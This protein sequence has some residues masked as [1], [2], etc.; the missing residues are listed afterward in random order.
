VIALSLVPNF[1]P[2][3]LISRENIGIHLTVNIILGIVAIVSNTH[4]ENIEKEREIENRRNNAAALYSLSR[5]LEVR[6][7]ETAGHSVRAVDLTIEL[8]K[9]CGINNSAH[10][11]QIREGALLHDI[12][13]IAIPD[14]ILMK[15]GPL[16][17]EDWE[18]VKTHPAVGFELMRKF[19]FLKG[20]LAIPRYH[21]ERYDGSGYPE[22]LAGDEIPIEARIF[23]IVDVYD[24]LLEKRP[25]RDALPMEE[26]IKHFEHN[27]GVLYDPIILDEFMVMIQN[28]PQNTISF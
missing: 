2:E 28:Q 9:R 17:D 18:I 5:A 23:A 25:Y 11:R 24:A 1:A 26:V 3:G 7:K 10:L 15:P 16:T 19:D 22:G 20:S 6:H 13:K 12:G 27:K 21:H 14:N 4:K 8:A